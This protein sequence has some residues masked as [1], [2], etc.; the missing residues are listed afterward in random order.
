MLSLRKLN[1]F[2][3]VAQLGSFSRA[4]EA[5]YLTQAAV[6]QQVRELEAQLG[7][8]LFQ[9]KPNSI[10]LTKTG[11]ALLQYAL[12]ML[13]LAE[14]AETAVG[15]VAKMQEGLLRI[16]STRPAAAT[17]AQTWVSAFHKHH[18]QFKTVLQT[19]S[20]AD[21]LH[22]KILSGELDIAFVE[23]KV[24]FHSP[25][26]KMAELKNA[27]LCV[28]F[29]AGHPWK[30]RKSVS[31]YEVAQQP[32]VACSRQSQLHIWLEELFASFKLTSQVVSEFDDPHTILMSVADGTGI[33]V[34][35]SCAFSSD[36]TMTQETIHCALI[37]EVP[38][39]RF[40]VQVMWPSSKSFAPVTCAFMTFLSEDFPDVLP[41]LI[42]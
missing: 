35:P 13:A 21:A 38:E 15:N 30:E 32:L 26:I 9:R 42:E 33:A 6:S 23:G 27:K 12:Q 29:G 25:K 3:K 36:S 18:P 7:T 17:L 34:L 24:E 19:T 39:I 20:D 11:G 10:A 4:A 14:Q 28:V 22:K 31:I 8:S 16:G 40:P 5:L 1:T 2:V 41:L 37:E